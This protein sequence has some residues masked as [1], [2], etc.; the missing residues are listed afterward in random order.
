MARKHKSNGKKPRSKGSA[1]TSVTSPALNRTAN[2]RARR[3]VAESQA[4]AVVT[5]DRK[6]SANAKPAVAAAAAPERDAQPTI[7]P[8][9]FWARAPLAIMDFWFSRPERERGA[10]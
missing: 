4:D 3:A 8:F 2:R 1:K 7:A 6:R 5:P 10:S 9:L